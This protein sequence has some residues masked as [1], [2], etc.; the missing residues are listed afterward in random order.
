MARKTRKRKRKHVG[1]TIR[2]GAPR[3]DAQKMRKLFWDTR[4]DA[5]LARL[6]LE[7]VLYHEFE[8]EEQAQS[9]SQFALFQMSIMHE[10]ARRFGL[11]CEEPV[12]IGT[13]IVVQIRRTGQK[14][15]V[16]VMPETLD[17]YLQHIGME[18]NTEAPQEVRLNLNLDAILESAAGG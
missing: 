1:Q 2:M 7:S 3:T 6:Q 17:A 13:D 4:N 15:L 5:G 14:M 9:A 16:R 18:F 12:D 10:L 8:T 11:M